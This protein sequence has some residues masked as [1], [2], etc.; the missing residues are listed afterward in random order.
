VLPSRLI[1]FNL[2]FSLVPGPKG[3]V[4]ERHLQLVF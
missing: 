1:L 2:T 3:V 4:V